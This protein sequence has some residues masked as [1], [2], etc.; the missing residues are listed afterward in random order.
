MWWLS[1]LNRY[2]EHINTTTT[3]HTIYILKLASGRVESLVE[4]CGSGSM[5]TCSLARV[6]QWVYVK[7]P[8]PVR[9][10]VRICVFLVP[11]WVERV[12][13]PSA[14]EGRNGEFLRE[15]LYFV[16]VQCFT[17][18]CIR[19]SRLVWYWH[20]STDPCWGHQ[21]M[22]AHRLIFNWTISVISSN[23]Q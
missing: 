22:Y 10:K 12:G 20:E 21:L 2:K 19:S 4:G 1:S 5:C 13:W 3:Y 7:C 6:W 18:H 9:V 16:H 14:W 8:L 23:L 15:F 17:R 11:A